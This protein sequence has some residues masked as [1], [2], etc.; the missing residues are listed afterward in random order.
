M[1]GEI[2]AFGRAGLGCMMSDS[3]DQNQHQ[4]AHAL[5]IHS[6]ACSHTYLSCYLLTPGP[7]HL[8]PARNATIRPTMP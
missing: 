3:G 6:C 8:V 5:T 2:S 4:K 1:L 7:T